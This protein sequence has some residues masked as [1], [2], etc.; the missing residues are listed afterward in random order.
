MIRGFFFCGIL[1]FYILNCSLKL[2]SYLGTL[3]GRWNQLG[4]GWRESIPPQQSYSTIESA[5]P[6]ADW[7]HESD[8]V[9]RWTRPE[10][11][12]QICSDRAEG[13]EAKK[14]PWGEHWEGSEGEEGGDRQRERE[15]EETIDWVSGQ[16]GDPTQGEA[17][18]CAASPFCGH[19]A[20][21]GLPRM[22]EK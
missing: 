17:C 20:G 3:T 8:V 15:R 4:V 14:G 11:R 9:W 19:V 22:K 2:P 10:G 1:G 7:R 18:S 13:K 12:A 21:H 6:G 16:L 5:D